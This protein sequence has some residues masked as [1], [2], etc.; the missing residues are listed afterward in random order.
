MFDTQPLDRCPYAE[1]CAGYIGGFTCL[2]KRYEKCEM[3]D[4]C[5]KADEVRAKMEA[6]KHDKKTTL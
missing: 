3:Y 1:Q 6:V 5:K 4:I 2:D